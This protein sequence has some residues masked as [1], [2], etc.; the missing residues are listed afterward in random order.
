MLGAKEESRP[1]LGCKD[2]GIYINDK[3]LLKTF[4]QVSDGLKGYHHETG[5]KH[6]ATPHSE[7]SLSFSLRN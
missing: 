7:V 5:S 6:Q 3:L 1:G 4:S 2:R